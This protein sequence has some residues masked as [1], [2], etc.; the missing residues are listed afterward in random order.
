MGR[1]TSKGNEAE[2]RIV[3][4]S[5][6]T[7]YQL[8]HG[9]AQTPVGMSSK[10]QTGNA[11]SMLWTSIIVRIACL[12]CNDEEFGD[13]SKLSHWPEFIE[14]EEVTL[15]RGGADCSVEDPGVVRIQ[16]EWNW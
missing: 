9:G 1:A 5:D 6:P 11:S 12:L 10:I 14:R 4:I 2:S 8:D 3:V 16:I 13:K 7:R 15:T